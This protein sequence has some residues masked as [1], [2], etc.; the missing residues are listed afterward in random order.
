ME[1]KSSVNKKAL[2]LLAFMCVGSMAATIETA[3]TSSAI[4]DI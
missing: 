2:A 3:E 1:S 4:N